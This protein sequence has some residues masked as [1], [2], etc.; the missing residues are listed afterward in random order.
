MEDM[1]ITIDPEQFNSLTWQL[2]FILVFL[3]FIAGVLLAKR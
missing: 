2:R 3:G 1:I